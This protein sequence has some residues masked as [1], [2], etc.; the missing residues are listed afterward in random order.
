LILV[1]YGQAT[2]NEILGFARKIQRSVMDQF[3]INLEL[4]VNVVG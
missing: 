3:G 2:G 1:N 4:E